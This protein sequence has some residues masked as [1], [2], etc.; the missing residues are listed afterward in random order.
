M[1]EDQSPPGSNEVQI[2]PAIYIDQMLSLAALNEERRATHGF[3]SAHGGIDAARDDAARALV[4]FL[5]TGMFDHVI[6]S[7]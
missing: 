1:P 4:K 3:E 6:V 7:Q 2:R 5:G